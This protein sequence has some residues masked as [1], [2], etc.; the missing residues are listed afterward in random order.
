VSDKEALVQRSRFGWIFVPVLGVAL[1]GATVASSCGD[2]VDPCLDGVLNGSESDVDCGGTCVERCTLAASCLV[3]EDCVTGCC[4]AAG[5]CD[6][7]DDEDGVC[8]ADRCEPD[9]DAR[10]CG[11]DGC[12]GLCGECGDY[13]SCTESGVC[14]IPSLADWG[15]EV[16]RFPFLDDQT[17][18]G[19]IAN[20][21]AA[22]VGWGDEPL[23]S[24]WTFV[25]G[26]Y[27]SGNQVFY[28]MDKLLQKSSQLEITVTPAEGV[29][30]NVYA[31]ALKPDVFYMPPAIPSVSD[32]T[33]S[34]SGD[35]GEPE[36]V[37]LQNLQAP[38]QWLIAVVGPEGVTDGAFTLTIDRTNVLPR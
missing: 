8:D 13:E 34:K 35:A 36:S 27:F 3:A 16:T 15:P 24:C 4:N 12:G 37:Y 38:L 10:A 32:C 21:A 14:E 25:T 28:A 22:D 29:D 33:Y 11:G 19:D 23:V 17:F 5:S 2:D 9:C 6:T 31:F 18:E 1:M 26:K 20:G 7:D 30:L